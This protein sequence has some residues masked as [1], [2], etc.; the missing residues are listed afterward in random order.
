MPD[1]AANYADDYNENNIEHEDEG[2]ETVAQLV[3][4]NITQDENEMVK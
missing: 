1:F 3:Q 4:M 2:T